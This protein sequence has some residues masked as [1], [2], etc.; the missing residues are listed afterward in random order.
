MQLN[1][2]RPQSIMFDVND[3]DKR[4]ARAWLKKHGF[5]SKSVETTDRYHH[6]RQ[7]DPSGFSSYATIPFGKDTGIK[8]VIGFKLNPEIDGVEISPDS[9]LGEE[10]VERRVTVTESFD[11]FCC[12]YRLDCD[13]GEVLKVVVGQSG[14]EP[15]FFFCYISGKN[16]VFRI[17]KAKVSEV[18]DGEL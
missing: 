7:A 6:F 8:A 18:Q 14:G 5:R 16:L 2:S 13:A 3:W 1:A 15:L 12:G 9:E 11:V 10:S 17:P 4:D